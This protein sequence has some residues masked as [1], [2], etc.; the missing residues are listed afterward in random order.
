M[1]TGGPWAAV[2]AM[3]DNANGFNV[4]EKII[5]KIWFHKKRSDVELTQSKQQLK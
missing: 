5:V 1:G 3:A 4:K 2:E